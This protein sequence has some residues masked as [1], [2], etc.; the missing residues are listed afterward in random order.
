ME[1]EVHR[2][3]ESG[4]AAAAAITGLLHSGAFPAPSIPFLAPISIGHQMVARRGVLVH[5]T[6]DNGQILAAWTPRAPGIMQAV[7]DDPFLAGS[8]LTS[9]DLMDFLQK[10]RA[11]LGGATLYLPHIAVNG[12][13]WRLLRELDCRVPR[14]RR[15]AKSV[16]DW[17]P[18]NRNLWPRVCARDAFGPERKRR[19]FERSAHTGVLPRSAAFA[20][21]LEIERASW[22]AAVG[23]DLAT[24][25]GHAPM[26]RAMV[27][28]G[29]AD[30]VFAL[31]NDGTPIAYRLDVSLG[32]KI[33]C[34]KS[35]F[36]ASHRA[37]SPGFYLLA[38]ELA[39]RYADATETTIDL[40]GGPGPLKSLVSSALVER[41]DAAFPAGEAAWALRA[42]RRAFDAE[43]DSGRNAI[44]NRQTTGEIV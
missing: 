6:G 40:L 22:K 1:V 18:G 24:F 32:D 34:L 19:R 17:R 13:S 2:F 30:A 44:E 16:I 36:R 25:P 33:F 43:R 11:A 21:I 29:F 26:Y 12:I 31:G 8:A 41:Y 20:T 14:W 7:A 4:S 15:T 27:E 3:R 39:R 9:P 38:V 10:T 42:E 23:T 35:S 5:G 37:I 28:S